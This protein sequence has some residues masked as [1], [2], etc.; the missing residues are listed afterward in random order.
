MTGRPRGGGAAWDRY[1]R[2]QYRFIRALDP[3]IRRVLSVVPLADTEELVVIGRR[4]GMRRPLLVGLLQVDGRL[5]V[6]H[7]NGP[8]AQWVRNLAVRPDAEVHLRGG[9]SIATVARRLEPGEERSR[10]IRATW[11]QHPFPGNVVYWLAR[12]HIE[13]VGT[14][15]RLDPT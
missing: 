11:R 7:P 3:L 2:V 9:E 10:A 1:F 15:F 6:G 14:Y 4:T 8:R 5:Y 12:R 13:A